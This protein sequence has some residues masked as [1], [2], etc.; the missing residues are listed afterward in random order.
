MK[1]ARSAK[2]QARLLAGTALAGALAAG[3]GF[4]AGEA[5]ALPLGPAVAGSTHPGSATFD[6]SV[7]KTLNINQTARRVVIDWS[8]FDI[9]S[10]ETVNFN[11][12]AADWV[13]FNRIGG[14]AS[15]LGGPTTIDGSLNAT[16]GVWL[17]TQGGLLIGSNARINVGS[18]VGATGQVDPTN[19]NQLLL[20]DP[21]LPGFYTT[22]IAGGRGSGGEILTVQPGAQIN[23]A[24]GFVALQAETLVQGGA[25][26]ASDGVA[27]E[28]VQT[29]SI[30]YTGN[31]SGQQ[32]HAVTATPVPGQDRPSFSHTGSTAAGWVGVDAPS[33]A[34][35]PGYHGMINLDGVIQATGIKPGSGNGGVVLMAGSDLGPAQ[36]AYNGATIGVDASGAAITSTHSLVVRA[37]SLSLGAATLSAPL[38]VS[39]YGDISL[40]G[41]VPWT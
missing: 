16:G 2:M 15:A 21:H 39:A 29:A 4:S 32:I 37:D 19:L 8:S 11:Q 38:D 22:A 27:Y 36:T 6:F 23:A 12:A 14:S 10:G 40:T 24:K 20:P 17:F 35:D 31:A 41:P 1:R 28:A 26:T 3:L 9:S 5:V 7:A 25:I 13:A 30:T 34:I 33:A 18:F